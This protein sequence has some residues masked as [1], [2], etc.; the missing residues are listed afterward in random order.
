MAS[1]AT[2]IKV[3]LESGMVEVLTISLSPECCGSWEKAERMLSKFGVSF[4]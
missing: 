2:A 4:N 1:V 3:G